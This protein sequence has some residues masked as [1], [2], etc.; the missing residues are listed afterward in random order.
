MWVTRQYHSF[1]A[2]F[3]H[4]QGVVL[5]PIQSDGAELALTNAGYS[6]NVTMAHFHWNFNL[7]IIE[8]GCSCSF[9]A[10]GVRVLIPDGIF[11]CAR[12]CMI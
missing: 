2:D 1:K 7:R 8:H 5:V 9:L 12:I 3:P 10:P 11:L 6:F 4:G